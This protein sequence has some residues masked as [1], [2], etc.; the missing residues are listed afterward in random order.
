MQSV[1]NWIHKRR[2]TVFI[3]TS[4]YFRKRPSTVLPQSKHVDI[5]LKCG[6][7]S[8]SH[9][10]TWH[11]HAQVKNLEENVWPLQPVKMALLP[12]MWC[13]WTIS[14]CVHHGGYIDCVLEC[15]WNKSSQ[16]IWNSLATF[17][18]SNFNKRRPQINTIQ[19]YF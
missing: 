11:V 7:F 4:Y 2:Y 9:F 6:L 10:K 13:T 12:R 18:R 19:L 8:W 15:Y 17:F 16:H 1:S 14:Y 5:V 3:G